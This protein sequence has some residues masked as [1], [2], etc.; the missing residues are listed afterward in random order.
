MEYLKNY[1]GYLAAGFTGWEMA[2]SDWTVAIIAG[3]VTAGF[4]YWSNN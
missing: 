4:A 3:L 2:H 1:G